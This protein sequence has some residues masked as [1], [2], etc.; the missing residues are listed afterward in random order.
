MGVSLSCLGEV[1]V[2]R[3]GSPVVATL[4][5]TLQMYKLSRKAAG[6]RIPQMEGALLPELGSMARE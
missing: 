3:E 6:V 1:L 2:N 5:K 4:C